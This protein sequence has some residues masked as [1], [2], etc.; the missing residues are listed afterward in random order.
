MK[1]VFIIII[2]LL[3]INCGSTKSNA[4]EAEEW[5]NAQNFIV[6]KPDNWR[7]VKH[8]GYVGYTP[9]KKGS[10]HFNT[11]ASLFKF[12]FKEKPVFK[13][14]VL[15]RIQQ[16][17]SSSDIVSQDVSYYEGHYGDIYIHKLESVWSGNYYKKH[18]V[19]F[20]RN[21]EFYYFKYSAL[22]KSY[23]EYYKE[24]ISILESITFKK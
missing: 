17:N 24:A 13:E 3:L 9:V 1:K 5:I 10:N 11:L 22:K 20:E 8:H 19:Y 12:E 4:L 14:F 6:K 2:S 16:T 7:A 18:I 23:D 21:G 15:K